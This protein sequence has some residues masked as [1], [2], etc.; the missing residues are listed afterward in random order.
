[1]EIVIVGALLILTGVISFFLHLVKNGWI[2]ETIL[3]IAVVLLGL[4]M[5]I[6]P[7]LFQKTLMICECCGR[8]L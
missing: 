4:F 2:L 7:I 1:M 5:V 8:S 6:S 3:S